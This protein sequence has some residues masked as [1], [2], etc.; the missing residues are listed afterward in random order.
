MAELF[1]NWERLDTSNTKPFCWAIAE[2][3]STNSWTASCG[4]GET[5]V[6]LTTGWEETGGELWSSC[7]Y[8]VRLFRTWDGLKNAGGC[9]SQSGAVGVD[10]KSWEG[11]SGSTSDDDSCQ[12]EGVTSWPVKEGSSRVSVEPPPIA[13]TSSNPMSIYD[14]FIYIYIYVYIFLILYLFTYFLLLLKAHF[15]FLISVAALIALFLFLEGM[16][17]VCCWSWLTTK[18]SKLTH[19]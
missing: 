18:W 10:T 13:G 17:I 15:I 11:E 7:D 8:V 1:T 9:D 3:F 5:S 16:I 14:Y 6:E 4:A 12:R 19:Q 2:S